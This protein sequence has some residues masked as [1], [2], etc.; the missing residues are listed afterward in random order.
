[1][2]SKYEF[3]NKM[4]TFFGKVCDFRF[5]FLVIIMGLL[6]SI[7]TGCKKLVEVPPPITST[8][9]DNVYSSDATAAAVLT[10]IYTTLSQ[11]YFAS[12][13]T[14]ISFYAGLSA[15]ELT[16]F[17]GVG[18][19]SQISYYTNALSGVNSGFESWN[20]IYSYIFTANSAIEGLNNSGSLTPTVQQQLIGEAKFIRAFCYFY[21]VNLYG[22]VP[23]VMSTNY[24]I[25]AVLSRTPKA[26]VYQQIITDIKD[27][28]NLLSSN[29]LDGTLL[30]NT[31]ER[32]R[33]TKW[34]ATA[35][36]ARTYLYTDSF[37]NSEAQAT[38]VINNSTLYALDTLNGVFLKNS[39]EAIW[40][41]Q[42]VNSGFNTSEASL[43][44][45]P[46]TGPDAYSYPVY[47]NT[48]LLNSFE[49]GDQRKV[50]W[51]DS[52]IPPP[53]TTTFYYPYKYK[54]NLYDINITSP[55]AMSE[56]LMVL[57][58]GEQYLIRAE[59]RAEQGD[60]QGAQADLNTI[61]NRAGLLPTATSTQSDLLAAI[62]HER[63]VELFT[64]WGHRWLD[65]KRTG[66]VDAIMGTDGACAAKGGNWNA[67]W[68]L[69]PLPVSDIQKDPNLV[70]N[71]GY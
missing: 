13:T 59:A 2:L 50:N 12:G 11:G 36:L 53:G 41:L 32:V 67:D 1:M 20:T 69:Y 64:E 44:I 23:L 55:A 3:P 6:I 46:P 65:M 60:I 9:A 34:A 4:K 43:Y 49:I 58:L 10:G 54:S 63:Q 26:Q 48:N 27:A 7:L 51:I 71:K 35:L 52:V 15:D 61:R 47:L 22:D 28:Q 66:T 56:Y 37:A 70:Q 21:L 68:Q 19:I 29:Y 5:S 25:N 40:Q 16:L 24:K 57:R 8:N 18:N 30:S 42:P 45:I 31:T 14:S 39:T 38:A 33:P 62:L 17:S